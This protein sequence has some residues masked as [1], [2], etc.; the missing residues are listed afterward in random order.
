MLSKDCT[1]SPVFRVL[2]ALYLKEILALIPN[3]RS[4][5]FNQ[6]DMVQFNFLLTDRVTR[7]T[8]PFAT[9]KLNNDQQR[10]T[11]DINGTAVL[12]LPR[13][14]SEF[15][16]KILAVAYK[17]ITFKLKQD[18]CKNIYTNLSIAPNRHIE[19]GAT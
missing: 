7:E 5:L 2:Y 16:V 14:D 13:N 3:R 1:I 6:A 4:I 17:E 10:I 15:E 12:N 9:I 11:T 8:V 19:N 18:S